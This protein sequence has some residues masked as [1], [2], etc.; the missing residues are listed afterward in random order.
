VAAQPGALALAAARLEVGI[1]RGQ[2][3]DPRQR[4]QEVAPGVADQPLHLA[5]VVA[6][7]RAAEAVGE[8]VVRLQLGEGAG[9]LARAVAEDARHRQGG[10]S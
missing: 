10:V 8:E 7:A 6:L 2:A 5:F 9:A 3:L 1:E 4:H